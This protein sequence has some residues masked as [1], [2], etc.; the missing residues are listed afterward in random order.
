VPSAI[1]AELCRGYDPIT[2]DLRLDGAPIDGAELAEMLHL[3]SVHT[4]IVVVS[5]YLDEPTQARLRSSGITHILKKPFCRRDLSKS[6]DR[7]AR[8]VSS[9]D[10]P[11][12]NSV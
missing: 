1:G 8:C 6:V 3:H 9:G 4:P 11:E 2:L 7:A 10:L 12:G 5:A